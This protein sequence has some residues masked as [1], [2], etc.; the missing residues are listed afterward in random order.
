M[1]GGTAALR[2]ACLMFLAVHVLVISG[3]LLLG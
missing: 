2:K 1:Q 3:V